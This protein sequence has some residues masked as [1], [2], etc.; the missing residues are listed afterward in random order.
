MKKTSIILI[1][2][3][4]FTQSVFSQ[5][6][7]WLTQKK[8]KPEFVVSIEPTFFILG[9]LSDYM[10]RIWSIDR[11]KQ[12]DKYYP[13]ERPF[14]A[15]LTKYIQ[16]EL[17]ITVD[18]IF[19][20]KGHCK[21]YSEKLSETLNSFYEGN[22]LLSSKFKTDEQIYS[23]LTGV[24]YRYGEKLDSSIYKIQL[25]NS[26]KHNDCYQFLKQVGCGNIFYQRL[27]SVPTMFILYFEPTDILKAYLD[28]IEKNKIELKESFNN[29]WTNYLKDEIS[30]DYLDSMSQTNRIKE[31][32]RIKPAFKR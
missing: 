3:L 26:P 31:L 28:S 11:E 6:S 19:E 4:V 29:F 13:Y 17:N 32:E 10:G 21:M 8:E 24:Y 14:V 2:F 9:T 18:T 23:F 20:D 12:V 1:I 7:P 27:K 16:T 15:F 5:Q 30:K 25:A 22:E